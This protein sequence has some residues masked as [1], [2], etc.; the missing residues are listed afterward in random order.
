MIPDTYLS[1]P[2]L[3]SL[4]QSLIMSI[5]GYDDAV[6]GWEAYQASRRKALGSGPIGSFP[7]SDPGTDTGIQ[8]PSDNAPI[9]PFYFV[10]VE[11][12][13]DG[14]PAW[15]INED[16]C[17]IGITEKDSPWNRQRNRSLELYDIDNCNETVEYTRII[18]LALVLYG[19]NSYDNS[20]LIKDTLFNHVPHRLLT[21]NDIYLIPDIVSAR[22]LPELFEG[23]WWKRTDIAFDFNEGIK[24]NYLQPYVKSLEM[25]EN[26]GDTAEL[27]EVL[28]N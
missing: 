4:F 26:D 10:R 22:Y 17:F 15:K 11:W 12:P 9:N 1:I 27:I 21:E 3:N 25:T 20:Q 7:I 18:N 13:E 6:T 19:P 16:I 8:G 5:L 2:Q 28:T 14:A 23:R 24:R